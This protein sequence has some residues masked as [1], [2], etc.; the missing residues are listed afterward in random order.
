MKT[1]SKLCAIPRLTQIYFIQF[2]KIS[3]YSESQ[4]KNM[5]EAGQAAKDLNRPIVTIYF[6]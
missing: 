1:T 6:H 2:D 4:T 5:H 3:Y